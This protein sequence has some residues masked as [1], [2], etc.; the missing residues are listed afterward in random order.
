METAAT[1]GNPD[2]DVGR[3]K[4][5]GDSLSVHI[6]STLRDA[7]I[8][9][10]Y[11]QGFRLPEQKIAEKLHVSR[12]P[13][14]EA[15]KQLEADGFVTTL[16]RKSTKVYEWTRQGVHDLFNVRLGLEVM[17]ARL[18]AERVA[19]GAGTAIIVDALHECHRALE[20]KDPF[21]IAQS[22]T[23][24]HQSM[25]EL[26]GNDLLTSLMSSVA[27]RV[28]WLF[29]LTSSRDPQVA[30]QEHQHL[31]EVIR[32]GNPRLAEAEV[33]AHIESGREP[34]LMPEI[35]SGE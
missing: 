5:N 33:Y 34:S 2:P 35:F 31:Y 26:A 3:I 11:P 29:Y 6:Y 4:A 1:T 13:L 27:G 25:V 16:P 22:G 17:A 10:E 9:G 20:S 14:R 7:I 24:F 15:L 23:T 12:I 18:A 28:T 19:N 8:L 30:C 21:L 32:S